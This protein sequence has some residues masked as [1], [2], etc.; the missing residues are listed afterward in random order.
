MTN[1]TAPSLKKALHHACAAY[2]RN[3]GEVLLFLLFQIAVRLIAAVPL[4]ALFTPGYGWIA[5]LSPLLFVLIVMPARRAAACAYRSLLR[6]GALFTREMGIGWKPYGRLLWESL[7]TAFCVLLWS[8]PL[9]AAGVWA[10]SLFRA[11]GVQG[12]TDGLTLIR[13]VRDFGGGDPVRGAVYLA[14]AVLALILL[15]TVGCAFHSGARHDKAQP[16]KQIRFFRH[17]GRAMLAWLLGMLLFLPFALAV[18]LVI[19]DVLRG[20]LGGLLNA[21]RDLGSGSGAG[22]QELQAAVQQAESTVQTE[23]G[24]HAWRGWVLAGSFLLLFLPVF[25]LRALFSAAAVD[26]LK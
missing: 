5:W 4:I 11:E 3:F 17:R 15:M 6:G 19:W 10:Y 2:G 9:I 26:S 12:S 14:L 20:V 25:P 13:Q 16:P 22:E 1:E 23:A 8:A 21:V 24:A 18:A 7:K